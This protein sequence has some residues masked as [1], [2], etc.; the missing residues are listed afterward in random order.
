MGYDNG[1]ARRTRNAANHLEGIP[2]TCMLLHTADDLAISNVYPVRAVLPARMGGAEGFFPCRWGFCMFRQQQFSEAFHL[3]FKLTIAVHITK[4]PQIF[5]KCE[6]IMR[7]GHNDILS[8]AQ[9][10]LHCQF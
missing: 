4:H 7:K 10:S 6:L 8:M 9:K 5:P 2:N 1:G 3:S